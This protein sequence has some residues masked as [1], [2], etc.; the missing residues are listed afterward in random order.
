VGLTNRWSIR[1]EALTMHAE[2]A[3]DPKF[4]TQRHDAARTGLGRLAAL[5]VGA[6]MTLAAV[7]GI[8]VLYSGQFR[9]VDWQILG[10]VGA[11]ALFNLTALEGAYVARREDD[12]AAPIGGLAMVVSA[13]ALAIVLYVI[14]GPT[15]LEGDSDTVFRVAY[16]AVAWS[17]C[18]GHVSLLLGRRR[19]TDTTG[20]RAFLA[21]AIGF[22]AGVATMLTVVLVSPDA[23]PGEGFWKTLAATAI[24]AV[25]VSVLLPIGRMVQRT[26][27][28]G[29]PR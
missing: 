22:T 20:V 12:I 28:N 19:A 11:V 18:L 3:P 24:L 2:F 10:T 27:Q 5:G 21:A 17:V 29:Q 4:Q 13:I 15:D 7:V 23:D 16:G 25:L 9:D 6:A 14:W 26:A 8:A 1:G